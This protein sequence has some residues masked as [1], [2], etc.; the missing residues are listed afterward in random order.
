MKPQL[1]RRSQMLAL[2]TSTISQRSSTLVCQ[3]RPLKNCSRRVL[4]TLQA[5]RDP[6][7]QFSISSTE[8]RESIRT[9]QAKEIGPCPRTPP[10][11]NTAGTTGPET[12]GAPAQPRSIRK[13][14][15]QPRHPSNVRRL[16]T[17]FSPGSPRHSSVRSGTLPSPL[18]YLQQGIRAHD[19]GC[20]RRVPPV[21]CLTRRKIVKW[22]LLS[23]SGSS[24]Q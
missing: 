1:I 16:P 19:D 22:A 18:L 23:H 15:R 6:R 4:R 24:P 11:K 9:L 8:W 5:F 10:R 7:R 13:I 3:G 21:Y 12:L 14:R 2:G 20:A 17:S